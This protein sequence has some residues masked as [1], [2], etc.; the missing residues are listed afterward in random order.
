MRV[1]DS[2]LRAYR[3]LT[4]YGTLRSVGLRDVSF[5][6]GGG[7]VDTTNST[8]TT[9]INVERGYGA[10]AEDLPMMGRSRYTRVQ[11]RCHHGLSPLAF[12]VLLV[13]KFGQLFEEDFGREKEPAM[14]SDIAA[15]R[16]SARVRELPHARLTLKS[17]ARAN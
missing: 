5:E 13:A 9:E 7:Y 3:L 15:A 1:P 4:D 17:K 16:I 10:T 12:K 14:A 11:W 6:Y 8:S 2:E